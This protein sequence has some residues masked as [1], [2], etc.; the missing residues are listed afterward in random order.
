M[1]APVRRRAN[2]PRKIITTLVMS[3]IVTVIGNRNGHHRVQLPGGEIGY[4]CGCALAN[5]VGTIRAALSA[6]TI[7]SAARKAVNI[8][9]QLVG[10]PYLWGGCTPY[11]IDCSGLVQL[12]YGMSGVPMLRD[13]HMQFADAR[14]VPTAVAEDFESAQFKE[15]DLVF[16]G[17]T[18]ADGSPVKV[19]HVGMIMADGRMVHSAGG[20]GVVIEERRGHLLSSSYLGA[21]SLKPEAR[22]GFTAC[23]PRV[24]I[25]RAYFS[26]KAQKE[27]NS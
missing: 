4:V 10:T 6:S 20:Y 15:G 14:L 27:D 12:S 25:G 18:F 22:F 17:K 21:R 1:F 23:A 24:K 2:C 13:A 8:A 7:S 5:P 26:A 11:G 19:T 16:F 9:V 3:S